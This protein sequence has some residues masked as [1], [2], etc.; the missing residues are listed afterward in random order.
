MQGIILIMLELR[1]VSKFFG[2]L[3]ALADVS[4][5]INQ[6]ELVG[7]VGP[8]GSGKTTLFNV[9]SGSYSASRGEIFYDGKRITGWRPDQIASMGVVRTFQSNVLYKDATVLENIIRGCYLKME[10]NSWRAFFGTERYRKMERVAVQRAEELIRFWG[11]SE[12]RDVL[13]DQ[14][15]HG[16]KR[17]LG[18]AVAVAA[19][20]KLLL[21][22]EPVGGM[23]GEEIMDVIG[24]IR[25]LGRQGITV[26][27]VEH[28]VKTVVN[29][30][31][32]LIVLNYGQRIADGKPEE[33]TS[34][35]DVI[36]AYLGTEKVA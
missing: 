31:Q 21:L 14:L 10:T 12:A 17:R 13:A 34:Q 22:D 8:N 29:L 33:V 2:K 28:H 4:L 1:N 35:R 36:E 5:K 26:I 3:A 20:P 6:G 25:E 32:R 30:C 16:D 23:S 27:L 9:I 18:L 24:H 7:L 15:P 19:D 11:L